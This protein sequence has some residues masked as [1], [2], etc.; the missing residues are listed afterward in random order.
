MKKN[1]KKNVKINPIKS[2]GSLFKRYNLV[3]FIVIVVCG[4]IY[5]ILMLT[6]ILIEPA[7]DSAQTSATTISG[8]D[9]IN[10]SATV[11]DQKTIDNLN[12]LKTSAK[13]TGDQALPTGRV[14]PFSE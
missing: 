6:N 2:I 8:T 12:K 10:N 1:V 4:L 13:N 3:L 14:N 11:F 5:A 9:S 7:T